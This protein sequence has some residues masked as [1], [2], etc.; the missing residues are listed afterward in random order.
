MDIKFLYTKM[1]IPKSLIETEGK[2]AN[3][4]KSLV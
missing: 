3:L 2:N 1:C 4:K